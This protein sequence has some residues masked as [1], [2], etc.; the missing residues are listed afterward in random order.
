MRRMT[1]IGVCLAF[2]VALGCVRIPSKFEAHITI[3]IRHHVEQ[4][5]ASTLDFIEGKSDTLPPPK[6]ATKATGTSWLRDAWDSVAFCPAAYAA[7]LNTSSDAITKLAGKMRERNSTIQDLKTKGIIGEDNRGY[8][9]LA[10]GEKNL[11]SETRNEAQ[12]VIAADNKDRKDLY[13]EV[14]RLNKD[15]NLS[16]SDV[17]RIYAK[18]RL[19]RAK[20]GEWV[21]L[22]AKGDDFDAFKASDAGQKLG[23]ECKP[24]E[25]VTLK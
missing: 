15:Q 5:A 9:A 13:S 3:D 12:R 21:Q 20:A 7:T 19:K 14:A 17:E 8:L 10:P 18:E 22:P 16:V 6:P 24:G 23:S 1:V 4:Q 2:L 25:W 11:S